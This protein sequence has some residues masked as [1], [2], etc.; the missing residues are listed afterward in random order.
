MNVVGSNQKYRE[1]EAKLNEEFGSTHWQSVPNEDYYRL[2]IEHLAAVLER[3]AQIGFIPGVTAEKFPDFS[4]LDFEA[5]LTPED[6][7]IVEGHI[8]RH[9]NHRRS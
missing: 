8:Q 7:Q 4:I 2:E 6:I 3:I 9:G 1:L 5:S